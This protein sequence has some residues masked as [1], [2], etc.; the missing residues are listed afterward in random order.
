MKTL[1]IDDNPG[2][3]DLMRFIMQQLDPAGSHY[4]ADTAEKGIALIEKEEIRII[5]LDIE[6]PGMSGDEAAKNLI[7][8]YGKIDIIFITGHEEYALTAHRLHCC[9]FVTKPF[10]KD[11]IA[12]AL[13][14][15]RTPAQTGRELKAC[16]HD[17][18]SLYANGQPVIFRKE[19]TAEL[20]AYMLYKHG[21]DVTNGELIGILWGD[22]PDKQDLLRKYIKD[23]RD[24]LA[25]IG[26]D[27]L[28]SK[29][30]G[31]ICLNINALQIEGDPSDLPEQFGWFL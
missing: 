27:D 30:R 8:K 23:M 2:I 29:K 7:A 5:F 11:D 14:W 25:E 31:S 15:L 26:A 28:L 20:F 10:G 12:E 21:G 9:A 4:F 3:L 16:C 1:T 13:Q 24:C 6:M 17:H 18:F 19:R 22:E